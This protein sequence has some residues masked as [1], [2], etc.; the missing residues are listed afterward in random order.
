MK[1]SIKDFFNKCDQIRRKLKKSLM[2]NF[3]FC[4]AIH[5]Y[6]VRLTIWICCRQLMPQNLRAAFKKCIFHI[7]PF[8]THIPLLNNILQYSI[9]VNAKKHWNKGRTRTGLVKRQVVDMKLFVE[10]TLQKE[11]FHKKCKLLKLFQNSEIVVFS[12]T[13]RVGYSNSGLVIF[14]KSFEI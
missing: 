5:L 12:R 3:I 4:A 1:F 2:E 13:P 7:D 6:Y 8:C 9:A 14:K 11:V 10:W